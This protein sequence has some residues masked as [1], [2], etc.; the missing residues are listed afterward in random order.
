LATAT[1]RYSIAS[2]EGDILGNHI[3]RYLGLRT[4]VG[5]LS[6]GVR[7]L[8][9]TIIVAR[10]TGIPSA[11]IRRVDETGTVELTEQRASLAE[12]ERA[13]IVTAPFPEY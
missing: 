10:L 1:I 9:A 7:T 11:G 2:R 3:Y 8:P 12:E 13:R 6:D 5:K 4:G